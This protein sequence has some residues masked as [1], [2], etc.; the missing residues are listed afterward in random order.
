VFAATRK[1]KNPRSK[2]FIFRAARVAC[3]LQ[4]LVHAA[5]LLI[6]DTRF[7]PDFRLCSEVLPLCSPE[8][9]FLE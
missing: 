4:S 3:D 9:Y 5:H 2:S 1:L 6:H 7:N 8:Y